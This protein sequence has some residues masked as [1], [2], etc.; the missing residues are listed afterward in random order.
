LS[1][2]ITEEYWSKFPDTYDKNMEYVVGKELRDEII[3]E[4]NRLPELGEL[5][6]LQKKD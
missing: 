3:E 4:L 2:N 1:D 5:V 6:E